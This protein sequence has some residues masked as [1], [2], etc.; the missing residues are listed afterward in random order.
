MNYKFITRASCAT[1]RS[2][3]FKH[4]DSSILTP[5]KQQMARA[6]AFQR[7]GIANMYIESHSQLLSCFNIPRIHITA[8]RAH[9]IWASGNQ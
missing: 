6:T 8:C 5:S 7:I 4:M 1:T 2:T 3:V 9:N